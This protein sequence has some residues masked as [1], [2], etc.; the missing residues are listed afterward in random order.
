[1]KRITYPL[2]LKT[3]AKLCFWPEVIME[4][5]DQG[6]PASGKEERNQ[7]PWQCIACLSSGEREQFILL[8]FD[9]LYFNL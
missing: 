3:W 8:T 5:D 1:M 2:A 4:G 7:E 9:L 6:L